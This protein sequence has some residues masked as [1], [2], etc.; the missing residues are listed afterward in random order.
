MKRRDFIKIFGV[1]LNNDTLVDYSKYIENNSW[2]SQEGDK[3]FYNVEITDKP[4]VSMEHWIP[5]DSIALKV[6]FY[7]GNQYIDS[8]FIRD[9]IREY[10]TMLPDKGGKGDYT[11][12]C[13]MPIELSSTNVYYMDSYVGEWIDGVLTT[14]YCTHYNRFSYTDPTSVKPVDTLQDDEPYHDLLGR[15][16]EG[17][18][19][20][21]G[22]YIKGN[23]TVFIK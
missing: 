3:W 10:L 16:I 14:Y 22:I 9:E 6:R 8:L 21:K 7:I 19:E 20:R 17:I 5:S 18:P 1:E 15:P 2:F 23:R 4:G 11:F 12:K 13:R